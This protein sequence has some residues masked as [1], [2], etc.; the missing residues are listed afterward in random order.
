LSGVEAVACIDAQEIAEGEG[1][2]DAKGSR[3]A[4]TQDIEKLRKL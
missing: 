2:K 3:E 4:L 1:T